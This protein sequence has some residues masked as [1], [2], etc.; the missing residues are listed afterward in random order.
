MRPARRT[1][2]F[3]V[4]VYG[5]CVFGNFLPLSRA[6]IDRDALS[7]RDPEL[8]MR[9]LQSSLTRVV[10]VDGARVAVRGSDDATR[11]SLG[12]GRQYLARGTG[13][14]MRGGGCPCGVLG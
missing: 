3:A 2:V 4:W 9:L 6:T 1:D 5:G 12:G 11:N 13:K 10:I 8:V 7:R 14:N